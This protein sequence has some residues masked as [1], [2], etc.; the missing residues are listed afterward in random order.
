MF[1]AKV[2]GR[3]YLISIAVFALG[4][5]SIAMLIWIYHINEEQRIDFDICDALM[6]IQNLASS[7]Q[8]GNCNWFNIRSLSS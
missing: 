2:L 7:S 6:D 5:I 8:D 1:N 4:V 3:W